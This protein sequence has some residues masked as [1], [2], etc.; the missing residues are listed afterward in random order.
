MKWS[1][2]L[3]A[4]LFTLLLGPVASAQLSCEY[5]LVMEDDFGDGWNGGMLTITTGGNSTVYS[6]DAIAGSYGEASVTVTGGDAIG[7]SYTEGAFPYEVSYTLY[8]ANG[9]VVFQDGQGGATPATGIVFTGTVICPSCPPPPAGAVSVDEV[10]AYTADISW[11]PSD[12]EGVY[13]I[14]YDTAGFSLGMGNTKTVSGAATRL[15]NLE[16][17]T[18]YDFYITA[19]CA[20]GDTSVSVGPFTFETLY[21]KDVGV[22]EVLSPV[23]GCGLGAAETIELI[24][25]NFGGLPQSLIPFNFS[26]NGNPGG[27]NQPIDGFYT[28]V[29]GTDSMEVTEFDATVNLSN[30]GDYTI[31][32]WTELEGDSVL[33]NDTTTLLVVSIPLIEEYPYFDNFEE[34]GGGWTVSRS[35]SGQA[36]WEYG[37]PSGTIINSAASGSNAWVTNLEGTYNNNEISY[38]VSPCLDFSTLSEDPRISFQVNFDSESCCDEA[39]VEVSTNDGDT[40]SKVGTAGTGL[41]WYNDAG[42]NWWDGT[43]GF[44]GWVY[45]QNILEGTANTPDV[46][47]RFVLS[48]DGSVVR[49]GM[50]ID[51]VL[52]SAVLAAD[53]AASTVSN[54]STAECGSENDEVSFRIAN[55]GTSAQ[56]GFDVGYSVNGGPAV[57]ENV[58]SLVLQPGEVADYVFTQTFDSSLPGNYLIEAWAD[59]SGDGFAAND[60]ISLAYSTAVESPFREDF[61]AGALP[62]NFT[63]DTDLT[64]GNTHNNSSFVIYDNLYS[65]DQTMQFATPVIGPIG[66]EDTLVFDYRFVNYFDGTIPTILTPTDTL[67]VSLSIDCGASYFPVFV[68]TGN[69]H[70]PSLEMVTG[71]VPLNAYEGLF[72]KARFRGRWGAGDYWLDIDN[73][74]V[75]RCPP[76]LALEAEVTKVSTQDGMDGSISASANDGAGPY[77]YTWSN[78]ATGSTINGLEPGLYKVTVTDYYGC[79]DELEVEVTVI[80]STSEPANISEIKLAPNPTLGT[81]TLSVE[82]AQPVNA[83]IQLLNAMGQLLF[84]QSEQKVSSGRYELDL[85]RHS[86]G[87]YLVRVIADGEVRTAKLIKAQ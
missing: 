64:V 44:T 10:R 42:N 55:V 58:G 87:I 1:F 5:L 11:V 7:L 67:E 76:S 48:T 47:V 80:S 4:F 28:G 45:A 15:Y 25:S 33:F 61:E 26:V 83:R 29:V 73:I 57:I 32:V 54:T 21:A 18:V 84:E 19:Y 82:F 59:L 69:E 74:N 77:T 16:E 27:V 71:E 65:G 30:P 6:L 13:E 49:E 8:D 46:R 56:S 39:W 68:I 20:N 17:K 23:T 51:N 2:T 40:W 50:G 70:T 81:T 38:L 34:W 75:R 41:N 24:I 9:Q 86:S 14:Q 52:I 85:S 53:L 72:L 43:G 66:A 36:S 78:G 22:T 37:N 60:T 12:P 79:R 35:G 3:W 62:A 63:Y 31:Q